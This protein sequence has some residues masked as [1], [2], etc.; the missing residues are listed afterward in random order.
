MNIKNRVHSFCQ[1]GEKINNLTTDEKQ[2]LFFRTA[3]ENPW[4]TPDNIELSLLGISKF[5]AREALETWLAGYQ[6]KETSPKKIGVA[7]AGNIPMVG[8]HDLLCVLLSGLKK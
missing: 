5:L 8:F 1:L 2:Q 6:M 7:M 3:N 4:F